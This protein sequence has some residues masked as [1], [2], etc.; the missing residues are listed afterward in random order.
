MSDLVG[1]PEAGFSHGAAHIC[2]ASQKFANE[3]HIFFFSAEYLM[4]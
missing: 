3:I 4:H 2:R 1:N